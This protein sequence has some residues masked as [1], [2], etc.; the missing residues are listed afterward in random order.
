MSEHKHDDET[1]KPLTW[2][3]G[4]VPKDIQDRFIRRP[5][6]YGLQK[7]VGVV[8]AWINARGDVSF[9]GKMGIIEAPKEA[10]KEYIT[11]SNILALIGGV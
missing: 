2:R 4:P 5:H 7:D 1:S 10:V 3:M 11:M 9:V 8:Y 6:R